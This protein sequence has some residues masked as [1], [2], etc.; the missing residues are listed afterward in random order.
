M[1]D[2]QV[3][4]QEAEEFLNKFE[5]PQGSVGIAAGCIKKVTEERKS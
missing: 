4:L 5:P 2:M 1:P 3:C